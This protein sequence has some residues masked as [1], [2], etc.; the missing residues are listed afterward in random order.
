MTA[1]A[2]AVDVT[3]T[4]HDE[5]GAAPGEAIVALYPRDPPPAVAPATV[6]RMD[7]V[8]KQFVPRLLAIRVGDE[9]SFPNSDN[10]R[11]HVYS[12][13]PARPFELPLYRG[14][15]SEPVRFDSAGKVVL[16]C[17]IHDRMSAHIYV[18]D[19]PL[20]ALASGGRHS[21]TG[22]TPGDYE[23]AVFHP[24]QADGEAGRRHRISVTSQPN[25]EVVVTTA[26]LA[27]ASEEAAGLSPLER[28]FQELRRGA[29]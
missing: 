1:R 17:N 4:V 27:P 10:I 19:A 28:K 29:Q 7:Q 16:G 13:S 23:V 26:L 8:D 3:V 22:L 11:H 12:F 14:I 21:F 20:F 6:H 5:G 9:V 15:P 18:L 2:H 25:Q 24:R